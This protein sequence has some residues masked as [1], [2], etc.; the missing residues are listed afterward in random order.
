MEA[1]KKRMD[2]DVYLANMR[3]FFETALPQLIENIGMRFENGAKCARRFGH[4]AHQETT[5]GLGQ[6]TS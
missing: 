3:I 1:R 6:I 2:D 4:V 5:F